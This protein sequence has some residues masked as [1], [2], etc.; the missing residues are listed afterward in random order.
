MA[1][2]MKERTHRV[3]DQTGIEVIQLTTFPL[4]HHHQYCYGQWISPDEKTLLYF[5]SREL[6]RDSAYDLWRVNADGSDMALLVEEGSWSTINREGT[7]VYTGVGN[8]VVSVPLY[9]GRGLTGELA[10]PEEIHRIDDATSFLINAVSIDGHLLFCQAD[11][12]DGGYACIRINLVEGSATELFRTPSLMHLQLHNTEEGRLLASVVPPGDD[13][14]IYT[15]DFDGKDFRRLPFTHSTN[16]YAAL[17]TTEKV[18]T[19]VH[20]GGHEIEI[21]TPGVDEV[22]ILCEGPGY[23][24]PTC[25]STGEWIACDTNWPDTGL[26]LIHAPTGRSRVLCYPEASCGHPQWTHTHPRMSPDASYVVFDSDRCGGI[27]HVYA[28]HIPQE[29]KD[30][31]RKG[32]VT[33]AT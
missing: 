13:Y 5:G 28:A 8:R 32:H 4:M 27:S 19:T 21:A 2:Q 30:D 10:I 29:F 3:D 22:D 7:T 15:F 26:Y 18:I 1:K 23:W 11:L 17:G 20:H 33:F 24:H 25:D 14:G 12:K 6:A 16:H 31:L 9:S